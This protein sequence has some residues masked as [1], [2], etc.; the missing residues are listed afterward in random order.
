M[1]IV[2]NP[3]SWIGHSGPLKK[4][5]GVPNHAAL[6]NQKVR[7]ED[8]HTISLLSR[9]FQQKDAA[10]LV[11]SKDLGDFPIHQN[12]L[13]GSGLRAYVKVCTHGN[14][15][16]ATFFMKCILIIN[17][18]L[19]RLHRM[20]YKNKNCQ[21][22]ARP[23]RRGEGPGL[24]DKGWFVAAMNELMATRTTGTR[25][26][27]VE[28]MF[29]CICLDRSVDG[30]TQLSIH[31]VS[32]RY[33]R[34]TGL[35]KNNDYSGAISAEVI[36]LLDIEYARYRVQMGLA[37]VCHQ[38]TER[39]HNLIIRAVSEHGRN[40]RYISKNV[41]G[42]SHLNDSQINGR[43]TNHLTDKM[44]PTTIQV[45]NSV[46]NKDDMDLTSTCYL[47]KTFHN[48]APIYYG[49]H[50]SLQVGILRSNESWFIR[51]QNLN[52]QVYSAPI[53][54]N[55]PLLPPKTNWVRHNSQESTLA[56]G[57]A[58]IELVY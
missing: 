50:P 21:I 29:R 57:K 14:R 42:L 55:N 4:R 45:H 19:L 41:S 9:I 43:W 25:Q 47:N 12:I 3:V 52:Q 5:E 44:P 32:L 48:D 17:L 26:E 24:L 18:H 27:A 7:A 6:I 38:W 37:K 22:V 20:G 2:H 33:R 51:C 16:L 30:K 23:L 36:A 49:N 56:N 31:L 10:D 28:R 40:W 34:L 58:V 11:T 13:I 39:E 46:D 1:A 8:A 15:Y 35:D 54:H 53:D